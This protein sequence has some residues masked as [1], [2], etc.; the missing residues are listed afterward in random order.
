MP[1]L[2]TRGRFF[3]KVTHELLLKMAREKKMQIQADDMMR[4]KSL[5]LSLITDQKTTSFPIQH[6]LWMKYYL[7]VR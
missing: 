7:L 3:W 1:S 2:L 5:N 4:K 6:V